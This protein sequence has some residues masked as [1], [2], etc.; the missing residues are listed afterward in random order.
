MTGAGGRRRDRR[1]GVEI[2][3]GFLELGFGRGRRS[4]LVARAETVLRHRGAG[5]VHAGRYVTIAI[6]IVAIAP[7]AAAAAAPPS[8]PF[9]IAKL[10]RTVAALR[11]APLGPARHVGR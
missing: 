3:D 8:A 7:A 2:G 11:R 9:A 6:A 1:R 10:V 4:E 5:L